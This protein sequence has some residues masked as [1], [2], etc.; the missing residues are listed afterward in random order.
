MKEIP[1]TAAGIGSSAVCGVVLLDAQHKALLQHRDDKP[2]LRAANQWV[3]PG[4]HIEPGETLEEG[5]RREFREETGYLC[6]DMKWFLSIYDCF[7]PGWPSY[8]LH[9]FLARYDGKQKVHCF[10]GQE[11]RFV[12][13]ESAATLPMPGYQNLI[14]QLAIL[15]VNSGIKRDILSLSGVVKS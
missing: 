9:L 15:V 13:L 11:L 4:G 2:G 14:W 10:E 7:S 12:S 8:P 5:A 6:A 3:F 1:T